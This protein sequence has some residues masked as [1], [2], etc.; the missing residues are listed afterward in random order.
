MTEELTNVQK[1]A[2][3]MGIVVDTDQLHQVSE[4]IGEI[5]D[6]E[7]LKLIDKMERIL[8]VTKG[9][10]LAM[11]QIGILKRGFIM[12]D[13]ENNNIISVIN[14]IIKKEYW[15]KE[16]AQEGCLSIVDKL[17]TIGRAKK[18]TIEYFTVI[19]KNIKEV[20]REFR[21]FGARVAAHEIDHLNGVLIIDH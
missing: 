6:A 4:P 10:G 16:Y 5:E 9:V 11:P 13:S 19:N 17:I 7:L 20:R 8:I 18:I 3:S 21:D 1:Q 14:P 15:Q 12:Y 2:V